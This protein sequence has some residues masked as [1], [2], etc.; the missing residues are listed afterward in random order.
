MS[1]SEYLISPGSYGFAGYEA[2]RMDGY[3][4]GSMPVS[5]RACMNIS[6]PQLVAISR[7]LHRSNPI[8]NGMIST[9]VDYTVGI[10]NK[11]EC[12][13][14]DPKQQ[15]QANLIEELFKDYWKCPEI[16]GAVP[17][18][19]VEKMVMQE[20]FI[21]G[22]TASI[23][24]K[25]G[26]IQL[27]ESEQIVGRVSSGF[28]D[29][30]KT[31]D[32]GRIQSFNVCSYK[33]GGYITTYNGRQIT[34]DNM[35]FLAHIERPSDIRAVPPCQSAF[36][37]LH[38]INDVCDSESIAMQT[39]ARFAL[40]ITTEGA[41]DAAMQRSV[42]DRNNTP[43]ESPT[44]TRVEDLGYALMFH[45][46]MGSKLEGVN[47]NIPGKD[48]PQTIRTFLRLLG[49]PLGLPLELVFLDWTQSNYSQS[50]AVLEHAKRKFANWQTML[51]NQFLT[52][53]LDWKVKEWKRKGLIEES[54]KYKKKWIGPAFPW[55][56]PLKEAEA[57][58]KQIEGCMATQH[59]VLMSQ[60]KDYDQFISQRR[61][62]VEEAV[63]II[64]EIE[65]TQ[66][67]KIPYE[68]FAGMP[69]PKMNQTETKSL[70]TE[71]GDI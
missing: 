39:M 4:S 25:D 46:P 21:C 12:I 24:L 49:L 37:M 62:E 65:A 54:F 31:D 5:G 40:A 66:G 23:K 45:G 17:G 56:D 7:E 63:T 47:R 53:V 3:R 35:I 32:Y 48:F 43:D 50:R 27:I 10:G 71:E 68:A 22:D 6:R 59:D 70:V 30:I 15:E 67:V 51:Q 28:D 60:G 58:S 26:K 52:P 38:R 29:G 2:A 33:N 42:Q 57:L 69:Y 64:K 16:R 13:A 55:L 34:A 14:N 1:R 41:S 61:R 18:H 19:V 36:P 8:Y 9:A 44:A 20:V 11:L